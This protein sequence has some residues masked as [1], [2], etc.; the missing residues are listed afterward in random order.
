[1]FDE[2]GI[3][4]G[5]VEE[6]YYR[7]LENPQL[8]DESWRTYFGRRLIGNGAPATETVY[9]P[10]APSN[11][12]SNGN[13]APS[14]GNGAG[15]AEARSPSDS[16][17][18]FQ[19]E[20]AI[21]EPTAFQSD[22]RA[23]FEAL[24]QAEAR[25]SSLT[26]D[27]PAPLSISRKVVAQAQVTN[28][29][30]AY[31]IRGHIFAHVN[32]LTPPGE[33]KDELAPA[34]FGLRDADLDHVFSAGDLVSGKSELTLRE[35]VAVC[36]ETYCRNVGVEFM[37]IDELEER[38]WLQ[39]RMESTR[40]RLQLG[41]EEQ[42]RIL[43][44]LT[45]AEVLEQFLGKAYQGAKRFSL[46]GAE[47]LIPLLDLVVESAGDH[48]V[49]EIV[50][51]MAHRG[52]LNVLCNTL[53]K[54]VRELFAAFNDTH[55]EWHF[56]SG[57][58][59]YHLGYSTDRETASGRSVHLTLAFN[60]SHLEWVNPVVE[61]RARAKQ[62]RRGDTAGRRVMPLLIHGDAAFI[63]Q[64]VVPE[65]LNLAALEGYRTGGTLHVIVNN[66]IGFTTDPSDARS[67]RYATDIARML[68][69]P[70]FH[71]NGE[72]P[73]AVAQ[74]TRLAVEFRQRFSKD[75]IIDMYCFRKW[76]HNETDEPRFT[77]P[78]MYARIDQRESVR[79]VYVKR[80]LEMGQVSAEQAQQI[81]EGRR[82]HLVS[83][84]EETRK[85][86]FSKRPDAMGGVWA[87]YT[88]G[89]DAA[90]PEADTSVDPGRLLGI[91]RT[92]S[93][94]P[95]GFETHKTVARIFRQRVERAEKGEG[96][97]WG[98][99][100]NLAVASLL[101]EGHSVRIS[102][103][104]A[105]RG[106]FTHRHA[107]LRDGRTGEKFSPMT[108]VAASSA[109]LD[110][111]DS[112]LSESG[113]L[114]FDYGY[115]LDRPEMLVCWEAQFGDFANSAQVIIDQFITA[116]EDKWHRLSSIVLLLPHGFE[117]AGPEHSSAR[118]E[119]FLQLAAEDNIQVCNLTTPAQIF[120]ALRRQVLRPLR[121]PLVI[122]TPKS[123]LRHP[124]ATSTLEEIGRG[125]YR[126][127]LPDVG[128]R[129]AEKVSR[130]LLCSGKVYYELAAA[131]RE[132]GADDVAI[133]RLEQLYPLN[134]EL[135]DALAPYKDGTPLVWV[136][137]EPWNMGAWFYINA[138]LPTML[139]RRLPL[140]CVSR[141]ETASPATGSAAA[142]KVEQQMLLDA[143]FASLKDRAA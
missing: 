142:H 111:F 41:R 72:D 89:A 139:G 31:R 73:E 36:D 137:E 21:T 96:L 66:Q 130:V 2:F 42:I 115:S 76:G 68:K 95:E 61:G 5:F 131:R 121:K 71:V 27:E 74:V 80:L 30:N 23:R 12:N 54:N 16:P 85:S 15:H 118:L 11:G 81:A 88:G 9:P 4:A 94:T 18:R 57:D 17:G 125:T 24:A 47:S 39:E 104:D 102:G 114:G 75:A 32:P 43:T 8:V 13:G 10:S 35:I 45:D 59:K 110:V 108:Q 53:D 65:T 116:A 119:R 138:R 92:I 52:R 140:H 58:V 78:L 1:M 133:V 122:M 143:A 120:H 56:G 14:N 112:P 128:P 55:P 48:A 84:L 6:Q 98:T 82:Q 44:K 136:Q 69:I 20:V 87:K 25:R 117:G 3:N 62:E 83:A 129:D 101:A 103:Q 26:V 134:H 132:R 34:A 105:R 124:D 123:Y 49:E 46:E 107:V 7:F 99:A 106:T 38:T 64:G 60:P 113:V 97:D 28:L 29:V 77:Q 93:S 127:V 90:V 70:I 100:E 126:R 37:M 135:T 51:G 19:R 109:K 63:G 91:L 22:A 86:D 50:I 67:T 141:S 40:N 79:D 33:P